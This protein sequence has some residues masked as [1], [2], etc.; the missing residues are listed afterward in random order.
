MSDG[1]NLLAFLLAALVHGLFASFL[2]YS[3][4]W[5]NPR[6]QPIEIELWSPPPAPA[7]TISMDVPAPPAPEPAPPAPEP[8]PAPADIALPKAKLA[9]KA[10]LV[11]APPAAAALAKPV[12]PS[13]AAKPAKVEAK[14]DAKPL[15]PAP[16]GAESTVPTPRSD[17]TTSAEATPTF[18]AAAAMRDLAARRKAQADAEQQRLLNEYK[19]QVNYRVKRNLKYPDDLPGNPE[20]TYAVVLLPDMSVLDVQLKQSSG[21]PAFDEAVKRAIVATSQFPPLPAGFDFAQ[22]RNQTLKFRAKD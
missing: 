14:A 10:P 6:Q 19:L 5:Q 11:K 20:A 16:A 17:S 22:Y 4:R 13:V 21:N 18:D 8:V 9:S 3:V 12:A 7:A 2:Y 15:K 1:R